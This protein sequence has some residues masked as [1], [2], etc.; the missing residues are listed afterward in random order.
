MP[1][2]RKPMISSESREVG[3]ERG[4]HG[5]KMPPSLSVTAMDELS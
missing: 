1:G 5:E 2:I 4:E 3:L